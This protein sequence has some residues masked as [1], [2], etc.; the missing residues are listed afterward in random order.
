MALNA[1]RQ[2]RLKMANN[3]TTNMINPYAVQPAI[4]N[5]ISIG[6][7]SLLAKVA[8]ETDIDILMSTINSATNLIEGKTK[9]V[10]IEKHNK[11]LTNSL[12][13]ILAS[14]AKSSI[15]KLLYN[16]IIIVFI[17]LMIVMTLPI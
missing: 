7:T 2:G 6:N 8:V 1:F 5:E 12:T 16:S 9:L 13:K 14:E 11:K 4:I 17:I 15:K 3:L 10:Q